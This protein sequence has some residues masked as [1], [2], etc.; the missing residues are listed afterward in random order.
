MKLEV[1][2]SVFAGRASKASTE[3]DRIRIDAFD[4]MDATD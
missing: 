3:K 4:A 2:G 1:V